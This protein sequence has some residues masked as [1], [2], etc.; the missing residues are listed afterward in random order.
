M[1]KGLKTLKTRSNIDSCKILAKNVIIMENIEGIFSPN[2]L[3]FFLSPHF[4]S[5]SLF[6]LI[7]QTLARLP[8]FGPKPFFILPD[9]PY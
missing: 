4:L 2:K 1:P 5:F 8:E 6:F 3:F 9:R 7:K